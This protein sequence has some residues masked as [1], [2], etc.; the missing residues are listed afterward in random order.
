[1]LD[2]NLLCES[3]KHILKNDTCLCDEIEQLEYE[4]LEHDKSGEC[5]LKGYCDC[6]EIRKIILRA[7]QDMNRDAYII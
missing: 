3:G 1:M 7:K 4:L 5:N 6:E 2:P